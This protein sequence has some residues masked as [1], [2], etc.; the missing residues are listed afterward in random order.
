MK[1]KHFALHLS[2]KCRRRWKYAAM[3]AA[4]LRLSEN[5]VLKMVEKAKNKNSNVRKT[6]TKKQHV[7]TSYFSLNGQSER[8]S[9]TDFR[10]LLPKIKRM[11][12]IL[13]WV[14]VTKRNLYSCG[15]IVPCA[16]L[17]YRLTTTSLS[18]ES[19]TKFGLYSSKLS[20]IFWEMIEI[21]ETKWENFLTCDHS[22]CAVIVSCTL[23]LEDLTVYL[24]KNV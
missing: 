10:F 1:Q 4:V 17:L 6:L 23:M 15:P 18:Y 22:Y 21:V 8:Q 14:G 9:L 3:I 24:S 20:E 19:E 13:G 16:I 2:I 7:S 11:T 5:L 12:D